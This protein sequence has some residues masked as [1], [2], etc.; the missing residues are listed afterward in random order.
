MIVKSDFKR[1]FRV[2]LVAVFG[3]FLASAAGSCIRSNGGGPDTEDGDDA[4]ITLSMGTRALSV[5]EDPGDYEERKVGIVRMVLYSTNADPA[6]ATPADYE[7]VRAFDFLIKS[8]EQSDEFV[9]GYEE[10]DGNSYQYE[11]EAN[12]YPPGEH[13]YESTTSPDNDYFI[14]WAR[15]VPRRDY[16]M[17][18]LINV[19]DSPESNPTFSL[20]TRSDSENMNVWGLTSQGRRLDEFLA[21]A[22][23]KIQ[24]GSFSLH[25]IYTHYGIVMTN[26]MGLVDIPAS[27]LASSV[28][29]AHKAPFPVSV[30]RVVAKVVVKGDPE[31]WS[32]PDGATVGSVYW[33]MTNHNK[34]FYWMRKQTNVIDTYFGSGGVGGLE[35]DIYPDPYNMTVGRGEIYAE[36]PNFEG[37]SGNSALVEAN[38]IKA[39]V[40]NNW[41][42][43]YLEP[44]GLESEYV[45]ENTMAGDEQHEDVMTSVVVAAQYAPPGFMLGEKYLQYNGILVSEETAL[46]YFWERV[47]VPAELTGIVEA[48][49]SA[50][51]VIDY[52]D[53]WSTS[54]LLQI[55]STY[56]YAARGFSHQGLNFYN[57]GLCY[58]NI[59]IRHSTGVMVNDQNRYSYGLY[60]VVR[61]NLYTIDIYGI[62]GLGSPEIGGKGHISANISV[63]DWSTHEAIVDVGEEAS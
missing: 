6:S 25:N 26:S 1:Y 63:M 56:L 44:E 60:G 15:K 41:R 54:Y 32:V 14:T 19:D 28:E 7:V 55:E 58:Y 46:D 21:A 12:G 10:W 40:N 34:R 50:V 51:N 23:I 17:L 20:T 30:D 36:D 35:T 45:L 24:Y 5:D 47:P 62:N 16:K 33:G 13:L 27:A 38:F 61:N 31:Y 11:F 43:Y 53:E 18:I 37:I 29:E 52:E 39:D 8:V 48:M 49:K 2:I 42:S 9:P 3:V 4:Y 59:P 22:T 57:D